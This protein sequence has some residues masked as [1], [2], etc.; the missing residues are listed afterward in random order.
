[1][2][3]EDKTLNQFLKAIEDLD[4][5]YDKAPNPQEHSVFTGV[6]A[7][8]L[9]FKTYAKDIPCQQAC[10]AKTN[11]S[12]YIEAIA[13]GDPDK[14]YLIN[15]ED[16]V[17]SGVLGRVCSRPCEDACRH[18]WTGTS[19]PVHICHLKRSASDYKENPPKPLPG[20]FEDTSKNVA[21]IG[22][23]PA[24]LTAARELRRYGHNVTIYERDSM[25]GGMMVQGI[26][27]FRL[28]RET[29]E[30]EVNAIIESGIH[31]KYNT[32]ASSMKTMRC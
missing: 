4:I 24:G 6:T 14:A 27:I 9:D 22:G 31:V 16:N 2:S 5:S 32:K 15:Q 25:L 23:G 10:P 12:A 19:G 13:K 26:P 3:D 28:P 29:V 17:F 1:M 18:N 7:E 11:V 21:I 20:W 8:P 30:A